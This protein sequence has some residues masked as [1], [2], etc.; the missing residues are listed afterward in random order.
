[1]NSTIIPK[2]QQTAYQR[3]E[4]A[5]FGDNRP[6]ARQQNAAENAAAAAAVRQTAEEIAQLR[7]QARNEGYAAGL[8]EGRK[9]G[10]ETG[11][12]AA[13]G[14]VQRLAGI[15]AGF[16]EAVAQAHDVVADD[17]L[18]LA[19]DLAKAMLKSALN[20]R[21]ELVLP[22]VRE[23]IHYL[24][25]LQQPSL[26]VLNP[27]DAALLKQQMGDELSKAGWRISEDAKMERGGCRVETA[28]N[29]IDASAPLRWQRIAEALGKQSDW[30]E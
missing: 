16:T 22:V 14:E 13:A 8:E 6:S 21:P 12:A 7:E 18:N 30:L 2:E 3:W 5:S 11:R 28:S 23:A 29:H 1:M 9:K 26:L 17:L 24:P 19:L 25:G 27:A 4:L 15:A 20:V 10:L